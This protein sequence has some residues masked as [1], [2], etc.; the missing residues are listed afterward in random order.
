MGKLFIT[1]GLLGLCHAA[2][3]ATQHRSYLRLIESEFTT[4]PGDILLETFLSLLAC[5]LGIIDFNTKFKS[6]KITSEWENKTWNNNLANR[7]SFYSFNH[8][9]KILFGSDVDIST[10]N[11]TRDYLRSNS[12]SKL[13]D[14]EKREKQNELIRQRLAQAYRESSSSNSSCSDEADVEDSN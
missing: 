8:R 11:L 3:S 10:A 14:K 12:N 9:G 6:I 13:T 5:C 1:I 4:L 2:Y 7:S